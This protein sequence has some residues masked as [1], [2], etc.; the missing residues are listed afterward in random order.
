MKFLG[1]FI[2]AVFFLMFGYLLLDKYV[3][4]GQLFRL[5]LEG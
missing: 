2:P 3:F 1:E 4:R 5:F